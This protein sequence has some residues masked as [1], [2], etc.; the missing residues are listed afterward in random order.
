[1]LKY[2]LNRL[3][4]LPILIFISAYLQAQVPA[5]TLQEAIQYARLN[6]N[7]VKSD[8]LKVADADESIKEYT[9]IGL[10]KI[11]GNVDYQHYIDIPTSILPAGSFFPGDPDQ[12]IPPNPEEDLAVQFGVK[13]TLTASVGA[14]L[15]I[16]DGSFFVGLRASK[17]FKE[18]V[19]KQT[20]ITQEDLGYEVAKAY[21]GVVVA[22]ENHEI[23]L[24]NIDVI[25]ENYDESAATYEQG[26]IEKL[27]LDRLELT[28]NNLLRQEERVRSMID[29]SKNVLKFSMG[30]PIEDTLTVSETIEDLI[31]TEYEMAQYSTVQPDFMNRADYASMMVGNELNELNIKRLQYRYLPV[32]RGFG[33]YSQVLQ[34]NKFADGRWFPTSIV[35]LTL[36][37]PIFDGMDKK[38]KIDRAEIERDQ[39]LINIDNLEDAIT[40]EVQ[41]AKIAFDNAKNTLEAAEYSQTLAQKIY[42]TSLIKYREGVGSSLEL[43]QSERDLYRSQ[44][45][46]INALYEL[47]IARVELER[48]LGNL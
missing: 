36:N 38:V 41:N 17:V 37:V 25:R 3:I 1:M 20:E 30:Y 29:V 18:L 27:D 31:L 22:K 6:H 19:M 16:F 24:E 39:H 23:L 40:L 11:N 14:D 48:S 33:N 15:L 34:G 2:R 7:K 10:P 26:F 5:F 47:L 21:L 44:G 32:L 45:E 28:L 35:G 9:A 42:D 13:N 43:T 46:Y 8:L 4:L 12:G